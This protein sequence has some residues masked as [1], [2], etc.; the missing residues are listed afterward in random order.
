MTAAAIGKPTPASA[1]TVESYSGEVVYFYAF[2][3]AYEMHRR[4]IQTLLGQP[5]VEFALDTNKRAPRQH[6]FFRPNTVRLPAMERI[7]PNGPLRLE[8]VIK[9]LPVGAI[10]ITIRVPF[11]VKSLDELTSYHD[12]RFGDG[13]Y[14]YEE[15]RRLAN[16]VRE[17][18]EPF[19][20]RPVDGSLRDE[21]A[22]TVF[23]LNAQSGSANRCEDWLKL[24]RREVAAL[25][26]EEV[27]H[28]RLSDQEV[29]ESTGKWLSYYEQDLVVI[30]WDAALVIDEPRF[31]E[32]ALYLIEMANLQLAELEAYDRLLDGAVERSYRDIGARKW[33]TF[34]TIGIPR[35]L[36]ELR[37]DLARLSD[38]L[39]NT[40]KFFGD[41]HMARIYQALSDRFH[42]E[43]W[44]RTIDEKLKTLDELYQLLR[45]EQNNRWMLIL[46]VSIVV[47]FV[48]D[49]AMLFVRIH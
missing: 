38:E 43:E 14:L 4:P 37:I 7:T 20:V 6:T 13:T 41:W 24:H 26:T 22:Y 3:V 33:S 1:E 46:E 23:C 11:T 49:L 31:F 10:S 29:E 25:L 15:V 19:F 44:H 2:D 27:D 12:L 28:G 8:R 39:L 45:S 30:D 18:L 17:E 21:E 16:E 9:I 47:L 5:V 34:K 42:L 48:V 35:D 36:R 32:E 40:T